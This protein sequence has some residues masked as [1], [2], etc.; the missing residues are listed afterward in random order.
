MFLGEYAHTI[1]NKG[2]LQIPKKFRGDLLGGAIISRGLDGC[3]FLYPKNLW[4]EFEAK[5]VSLPITKADARVFSRHML[6]G[7]YEVAID[8]IGRLLIPPSLRQ[9]AGLK[10]EVVVIGV[11][12]RL[13]LWDKTRWQE[14]RQQV[15][16][17]SEETAERLG[18]L[19]V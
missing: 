2:R 15:D 7:A 1:D 19:G 14:Y 17:N 6:A 5:L 10:E 11:G 12:K 4:A 3:L 8:R 16:S 18:E 13:E 9:Y